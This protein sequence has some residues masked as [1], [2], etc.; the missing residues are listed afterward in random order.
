M[1]TFIVHVSVDADTKTR[2][3]AIVKDCIQEG[4]GFLAFDPEAGECVVVLD[5]TDEIE[6]QYSYQNTAKEANLNKQIIKGL[7]VIAILCGVIIVL[8]GYE[9]PWWHGPVL[10]ACILGIGVPISALLI[11][12]IEK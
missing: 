6:E 12:W 4:S 1:K 10:L 3:E 7:T 5:T 2:A 11:W 8:P 9:H